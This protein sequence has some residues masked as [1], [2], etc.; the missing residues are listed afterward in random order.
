VCKSAHFFA[1]SCRNLTFLYF[2]ILLS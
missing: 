2:N 1:K